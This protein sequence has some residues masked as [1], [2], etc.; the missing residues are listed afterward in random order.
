[1]LSYLKERWGKSLGDSFKDY[2]EIAIYWF[3]DQY[4]S[5]QCSNLYSVLSTSNY[6]PGP[7]ETFEDQDDIIAS[8]LLDLEEMYKA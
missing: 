6:K 3:A 7:Y 8:M 4:H 5:G 1:M 2:A